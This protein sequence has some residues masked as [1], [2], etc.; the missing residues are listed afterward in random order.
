[1][2]EEGF[3]AAAPPTAAG[4]AALARFAGKCSAHLLSFAPF[5]VRIHAAAT[6]KRAVRARF[7]NSDGGGG[8]IRVRLRRPQLRPANAGLAR[9]LE[10]ARAFSQPRD[11]NGFESIPR[12]QKASRTGS[13]LKLRWRR[14]RDSNPRT[15]EH[16]VN[17]FRDRR[18]QP[19]CHS[20]VGVKTWRTTKDAP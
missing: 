2:E 14:R 4:L 11:P 10:N 19:L 20:S 6:K 17:G 5:R 16:R 18:I 3:G 9:S 12:Q 15:R 8:G 1:M 13:L 7:L